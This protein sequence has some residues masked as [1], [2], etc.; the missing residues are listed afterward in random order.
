MLN[1]RKY[2][3]VFLIG[4]IV[5]IL[6]FLMDSRFHVKSHLKVLYQ[7]SVKSLTQEMGEERRQERRSEKRLKQKI[8]AFIHTF[9]PYHQTRAKAVEMTWA[10]RLD[11]YVF[12]TIQDDKNLT[13]SRFWLW[14]RVKAAFRKTYKE[15]GND[16]DW[17]MKAD[18]DCYY[19]MENIREV[20]SKYDPNEPWYLG[21]LVT[22][23]Y[24]VYPSGGT[25]Y[26]LSR[27]ALKKFVTALDEP[28]TKCRKESDEEEDIHIGNCF[29]YANLSLIPTV[30]KE[31]RHSLIPIN[32]KDLVPDVLERN[33]FTK[34]YT[35]KSKIK[36]KTGKDC[37]GPK[38]M[39]VH[40]VTYQEMFVYDYLLYR[41]QI[42]DLDDLDD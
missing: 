18:D 29:R 42:A 28:K 24:K 1:G 14:D 17:F 25:G 5:I 4:F 15:K 39:A 34:W 33:V 21:E 31:G 37:C 16:F 2:R 9:P 7:E 11:D 22:S 26:I 32:L 27:A 6:M 20:L 41:V 36:V 12:S 35:T 13:N 38:L 8:F 40:K 3:Y 30:N 19:I 10:S 23:G